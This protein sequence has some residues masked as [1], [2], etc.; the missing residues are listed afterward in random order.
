MIEPLARDG[1]PRPRRRLSAPAAGTVE[2][3]K[4]LLNEVIDSDV[5]F[6][7]LGRRCANWSASSADLYG[8]RHV[9]AC[10]SGTAAMHIAVAA[11]NLP[12]GSEVIVPAITDMGYGHGHPISGTRAGIR[13]RRAGDAEYRSRIGEPADN[14]AHG[15]A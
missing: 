13:G 1:G 15:G 3:E 6:F 12:A 10:S 7:Y 8:M 2:I 5:L 11:L 4:E 9:V 14:A